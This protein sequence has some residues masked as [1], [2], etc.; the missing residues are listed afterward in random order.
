MLYF[1]FKKP[2]VNISEGIFV[3]SPP[4]EFQ[5]IRKCAIVVFQNQKVG[6]YLDKLQ[7]F[8]KILRP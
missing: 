1:V 5:F 4:H 2:Q 6:N 3:T 7:E 8:K